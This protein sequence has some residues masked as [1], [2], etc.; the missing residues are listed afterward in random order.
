MGKSPQEKHDEFMRNANANEHAKN[1]Q[2]V[3]DDDDRDPFII[4]AEK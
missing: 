4:D 2:L 3:R 1:D